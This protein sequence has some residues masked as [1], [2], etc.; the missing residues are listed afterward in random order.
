MESVFDT[1]QANSSIRID[2]TK[3]GVNLNLSAKFPNN[4]NYMDL[5][6]IG[7]VD[8]INHE[9]YN[10]LSKKLELYKYI[11]TNF[12]KLKPE[13]MNGKTV[14]N[15]PMYT[16]SQT[17]FKDT[18][19]VDSLSYGTVEYEITFVSDYEKILLTKSDVSKSFKLNN[20]SVKLI[21][22]FDNKVVLEEIN[23]QTCCTNIQLLNTDTNG[24]KATTKSE[25]LVYDS[26]IK[27]Y[28]EPVI[29]AKE[30]SLTL[31]KEVYQLIRNNPEVTLEEYILMEKTIEK[32][33]EKNKEYTKY[34]VLTSPAPIDSTFT[35]YSPN[36]GFGRQFTVKLKIK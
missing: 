22:I 3:Y 17:R 28:K 21:D 13:Y 34:I 20:D 15:N 6:R 25:P 23:N 12:R 36:Y 24:R 2:K 10:R 7:R 18:V 5:W 33:I 29:Y 35:I 14:P 1:L 31:P 16:E 9:L 26:I 32:T 19:D 11:S 8:I 4:F 27:A 30:G